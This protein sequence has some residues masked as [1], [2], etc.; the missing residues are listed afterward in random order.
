LNVLKV[1]KVAV[2]EIGVDR[3]SSTRSSHVSKN[4]ELQQC[5]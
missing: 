5:H 3:Q 2:Q 4:T 1:L